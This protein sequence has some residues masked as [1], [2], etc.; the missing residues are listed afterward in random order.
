MAAKSEEARPLESPGPSHVRGSDITDGILTVVAI[1]GIGVVLM[2]LFRT[3][4]VAAE[5]GRV[6]VGQATSIY[7]EIRRRS[8][9]AVV[10]RPL[11]A[12]SAAFGG[13]RHLRGP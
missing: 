12:H 11:R 6:E 2:Q 13:R 10:W 1:V 8:V 4:E 5:A 7:G 9:E 3:V